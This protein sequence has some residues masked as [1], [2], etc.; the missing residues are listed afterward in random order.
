MA[1]ANMIKEITEK[2]LWDDTK[3][4]YLTKSKKL[5]S[6]AFPQVLDR[7]LV[8]N[9]KTKE[10]KRL[11]EV[12]FWFADHE[13]RSEVISFTE[14]EI[15][16]RREFK[17]KI[18]FDVVNQNISENKLYEILKELIKL[19][20]WKFDYNVIEEYEYG[21]NG[22]HFHWGR[23]VEFP[24]NYKEMDIAFELATIMKYQNQAISGVFLGVIH[25]VLKNVLQKA[26]ISHDF[27]TYVVGESGIGKT[28]L[29]RMF[30]N[31][32]QN[33]NVVYSLT[34]D[35]KELLLKFQRE[36]D[37]TIVIDDYNKS[38]SNRTNQRQLQILGESISLSS[39]SGKPLLKESSNSDKQNTIHIIVTAEKM[40]NNIST[41][42]RCYLIHMDEQIP[43]DIW[44][45]IYKFVSKNKMMFFMK[46][47]VSYVENIKNFTNIISAYKFYQNEIL[48]SEILKKYDR[49]PRINNT[50][51]VQ[52]TLNF[53]FICYLKKVIADGKVID[54][55]NDCMN[56]SI[57][58][59]GED[60]YKYI[61]DLIKDEKHLRYIPILADI[62]LDV[63]DKQ[64]VTVASADEY[65]NWPGD[66]HCPKPC[67]GIYEDGGYIA[68]RGKDMC[69][70]ISYRLKKDNIP[71]PSI[72]ARALGEELYHYGLLK[73]NS[74]GRFSWGTDTRLYH[75]NI[76]NLLELVHPNTKY[77]IE[78][79]KPY[80]KEDYEE[81][82]DEEDYEDEIFGDDDDR[83]ESELF[84]WVPP[85]D[86]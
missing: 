83:T 63:Y 13:K 47:F 74:E 50:L 64:A 82:E 42:N 57:M 25:G 2:Y 34:S 65:I 76:L 36:E 23:D 48:E 56:Q 54:K 20:A 86:R 62:I 17:R 11:I 4:L 5:I 21:W 38:K 8:T 35:R 52:K 31:Y 43:Y 44:D 61:Q 45:K 66:S 77:D 16:S 19:Q 33:K 15:L 18:P 49:S 79:F 68:F 6:N 69:E 58:N 75:V 28:E 9:V 85:R 73:L 46:S 32:V 67:I 51:A 27:T 80:S 30:C 41:L 84:N 3:G 14:D 78:E 12:C 71:E 55:I 7:K 10:E 60:L 72:S 1:K 40:I 81:L 59:C 39:G 22:D 29:C 26:G 53:L 70:R 24:D 37:I